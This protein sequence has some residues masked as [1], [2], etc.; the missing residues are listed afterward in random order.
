MQ[1]TYYLL[2]HSNHKVRINKRFLLF[3]VFVWNFNT[4]VRVN[5][6]LQSQVGCYK[7]YII[8]SPLIILQ[9]FLFHFQYSSSMLIFSS[10]V[11]SK[12]SFLTRFPSLQP[13]SLSNCESCC[14]CH[15][16]IGMLEEVEQ[17]RSLVCEQS[18]SLLDS[19]TAWEGV[20]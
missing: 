15:Y 9:L 4:R 14:W 2:L 6:K 17:Y 12:E 8:C 7:I 16:R 11:F 5:Q 18:Q 13:Y 20:N 1:S 19:T 3:R 10:S